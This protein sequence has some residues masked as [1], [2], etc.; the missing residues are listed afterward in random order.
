MTGNFANF[1]NFVTLDAEDVKDV[2]L[3]NGVYSSDSDTG[4]DTD[5][6]VRLLIRMVSTIM[7]NGGILIRVTSTE[8]HR[9]W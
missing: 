4:E 1:V 5:C 9:I 3:D 6:R 7:N 2:S 8:M